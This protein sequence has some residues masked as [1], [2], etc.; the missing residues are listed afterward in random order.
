MSKSNLWWTS[1]DSQG[2]L[3]GGTH[4][5]TTDEEKWAVE[6]AWQAELLE[7]TCADEADKQVIRGGSFS[8]EACDEEEE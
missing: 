4:E 1:A 3:D 6:D 5:V 8:W 2:F 7:E